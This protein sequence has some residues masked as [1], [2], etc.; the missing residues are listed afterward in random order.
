MKKLEIIGDPKKAFQLFDINS[1]DYIT[2]DELGTAMR[3][4]GLNPSQEEITK[5]I[6]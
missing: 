1:D 5:L 4:L 2:M 3:S 6:S